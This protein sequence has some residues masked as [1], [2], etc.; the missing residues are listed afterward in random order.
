VS[1]GVIVF[2]GF[3]PRAVIAFLR[4]LE[5]SEV[6]Y[7]I[8]ARSGSDEIFLTTYHARVLAVRRRE[9]LDLQDMLEHVRSVQKRLRAGRYVI[10][11]STE[12]LNRFLL[13]HRPAFEQANCTV[14]L[15]DL[16]LYESISD[17]AAFT[18]LCEEHDIRVPRKLENR[19]QLALPFVAR[20]TRYVSARGR[21]HA[22]LLI[23]SVE[24]RALFERDYD[25]RDFFYQEYVGGKSYYLLFYFY[26]SR[27]CMKLSQV[28][29]VQ[30]ARGKSV[31][32][33][34]VATFHESAEAGKYERLFGLLKFS[35]LVMV[36]VKE[37]EGQC[38]MIEA[39]P[40]FWGPSQLFVDAGV[41]L[42]EAFL[43]DA[44][45]TSALP[46][47]KEAR[48]GTR[49]FWRGGLVETAKR[50][51]QVAYHSYTA[52]QLADDWPLWTASDVYDR[53]D[54]R[55]LSRRELGD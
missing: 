19:D 27:T 34:E 25:P 24:D 5:A 4:T 54:T 41:N 48:P 53:A 1:T 51:E 44:A 38:W 40:R 10:A 3:N 35:G 9:E 55:E 7:G 2:S 50:G 36:E 52:E 21:V 46:T 39:N 18:A 47:S 43:Y 14:P 15:V 26:R 31:I 11:P 37:Y 13:A 29:Y 17:K 28:N 30:Q 33:A 22:P 16:E 49:Y 8:I 6:D 45:V 12:A 32:A 20:P 23:S 42:F